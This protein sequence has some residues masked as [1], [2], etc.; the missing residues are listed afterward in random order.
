MNSETKRVDAARKA[1]DEASEGLDGRVRQLARMLALVDFER[2]EDQ[3]V[4]G[5]V[6][7]PGEHYDRLREASRAVVE[8]ARSGDVVAVEKAT[9]L[10]LRR[11]FED[12]QSDA[13]ELTEAVIDDLL[14]GKTAGAV[15]A[16]P[17]SD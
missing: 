9:L 2:R 8:E 17:E 5:F 10:A 12:G 3:R 4:F 13:I 6:T 14:P 15:V 1:M 16:A 7:S 11:A